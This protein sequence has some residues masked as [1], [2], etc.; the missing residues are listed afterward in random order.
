MMVINITFV[1][2]IIYLCYFIWLYIY[3]Y[4]YGYV[5][6]T[7]FKCYLQNINSKFDIPIKFLVFFIIN[8]NDSSYY[9]VWAKINLTITFNKLFIATE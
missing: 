2:N 5:Y 9:I 7:L 4:G 6:V 3:V 8:G 1:S